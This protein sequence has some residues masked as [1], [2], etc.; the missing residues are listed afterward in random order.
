MLSRMM[1]TGANLLVL[2]EPTNHLDLESITALNDALIA[3]SEVILF[4]SHDQEFV[5]TAANRIIEIAGGEA[6]DRTMD[7]EDDLG[8]GYVAEAS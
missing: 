7:Y 8:R 5:S 4:A 3:F 1:L 2:D 6:I